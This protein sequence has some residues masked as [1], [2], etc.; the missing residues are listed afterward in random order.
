[1][2]KVFIHGNPET[3]SVWSALLPEL[4]ARGVDDVVLLSPPGFGAPRPNGFGSTAPEYRDWLI[5]ELE[6]IGSPVDAVGHDWGAGH[7]YA[8]A[9]ERPDLLRTWV[10]DCCGIIHPDYVW[11]PAA[12]TWQTPGD[13]EALI[14]EMVAYDAQQFIDISGVP[15]ALAP[16]IAEHFDDFMGESILAV[17]RSAAQ[18]YMR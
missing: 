13:G 1:M 8:V 10:A 5:D 15:P 7:L 14:S 12:Q 6:R 16:S 11:H 4:A 18:P 2:T 17:Y 3:T 9:A